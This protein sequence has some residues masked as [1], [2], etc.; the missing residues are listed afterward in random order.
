MFRLSFSQYVLLIIIAVTSL[1][2]SADDKAALEQLLTEF[3]SGQSESHHQRFWADDLVY[4]SSSGMRFDKQFIMQSFT[5]NASTTDTSE[6]E[7]APK[8]SYSAEEIDIRLYDDMAIV[9]FKL[10][11]AEEGNSVLTYWNTGTFARRDVGWQA[12]A[13]QAT[14][15]PESV[16]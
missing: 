7:S 9:A 10:V 6:A 16:D 5:E 13:W 4:T 2:V 14:K 3:L 11:A 15:I 12:V 8:V 1:T